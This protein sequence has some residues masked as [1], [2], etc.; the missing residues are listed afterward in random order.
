M[1]DLVSRHRALH[2]CID[3][4]ASEIAALDE[5]WPALG[6]RNTDTALQ[7]H[8]GAAA[9]VLEKARRVVEAAKR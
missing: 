3:E 4:L 8:V 7:N 9:R 2:E 1:N 5:A 6:E